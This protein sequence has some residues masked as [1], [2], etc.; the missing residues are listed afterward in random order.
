[1]G[2]LSFLSRKPSLA[3]NTSDLK[4]QAYHETVAAN[5]PIRGTYP[6]A[7]N[8]FKILDKIQ[9]S[10]PHLRDFNHHQNNA[11]P[12]PRVARFLERPSTAPDHAQPEGSVRLPSQPEALPKPAREPP[13]KRHGPYKLPPKSTPSRNDDSATAISVRSTRSL[14]F[15]ANRTSSILTGDSGSTR[16]V[17][18]LDAQSFIRP[19]DFYGRVRAAGTKGYAEDVADRNIGENG[20]DINSVPARQFYAASSRLDSRGIDGDDASEYYYDD[21][22]D[23][24]PP[25]SRKRYSEGY[26]LRTKSS[27][28]DRHGAF[29]KKS[30]SHMP[31]QRFVDAD[32]DEIDRANLASK[33]RRKSLHSYIPQSSSAGRPRSTS[34]GKRAAETSRHH[35]PDSLRE[36]A[37]AAARMDREGNE[38][39]GWDEEN[40]PAQSLRK[41]RRTGAFEKGSNADTLSFHTRSDS[42]QTLPG[43][44]DQHHPPRDPQR[45]RAMSNRSAS[46]IIKP[47]VQEDGLLGFQ[48]ASRK[49]H[50]SELDLPYAAEGSWREMNRGSSTYYRNSRFPNIHDLFYEFPPLEAEALSRVEPPYYPN[51]RDKLDHHGRNRSA[52]AASKKSLKRSDIDDPSPEQSSTRRCSL[53]SETAGSTQ[54]SNPFRPQSGH[55]ANTSIDLAPRGSPLKPV[56]P[57]QLAPMP[58]QSRTTARNGTETYPDKF[59]RHRQVNV[60][61][62]AGS[63]SHRS[64]HVHSLNSYADGHGHGGGDDDDDDEISDDSFTAPRRPTREF[65][66]DLLF[67]GYGFEGAQLPGLPG[68]FDAAVPRTQT[69]S[70]FNSMPRSTL[71][72]NSNPDRYAPSMPE[73]KY[74][75]RSLPHPSRRPQLPRL[76]IPPSHHHVGHYSEPN[77]SDSSDQPDSS[78]DELNFDIPKT[79]PTLSQQRR[80]PHPRDG[81]GGSSGNRLQHLQHEATAERL[82]RNTDDPEPT[83][84]AKIAKLRREAKARERASG[85]SSLRRGTGRGRASDVASLPR[86]KLGSDDPY[87]YADAES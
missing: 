27:H 64:R 41:L 79:R 46:T 69:F 33:A 82:R 39:E 50:L 2:W 53:T 83:S 67:Q 42:R 68:L 13:K 16:F 28:S 43:Q 47:M 61:V 14:A 84:V 70:A 23:Y 6:V 31:L 25:P 87:G 66:R 17:D 80:H 77:Y 57:N 1:M 52:T 56:E 12:F 54:S 55:T 49:G 34:T 29:P 86:S 24:T 21:D 18:L 59:A 40:Y 62:L 81:G 7:G 63:L 11:A 44:E 36:N 20:S 71:T 65:E 4:A 22:D 45:P 5:P 37:L 74:S 15:T 9:K 78:E 35:F 48:S 60:D 8:G 26:G 58:R 10:N 51:N 38:F 19:S 85:A 32:E 75:T 76:Q 73:A 3:E 72:L 30:S